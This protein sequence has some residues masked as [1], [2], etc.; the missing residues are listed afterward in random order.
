MTRQLITTAPEQV[1]F[2]DVDLPPPTP[3][4]IRVRSRWGAAKHGTE[5]ALY[6]GYAGPRGSY[7]GDLRLFDGN[8]EKLRY[9]S[10]LGNMCVGEVIGVGTEVT[11][12]AAG[13]MVFGHGPFRQEH[14][15]ESDRVRRLPEGLP[16]QAAVCLDPAD[17]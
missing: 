8:G 4:Q 3:T 5:M 6:K 2:G 11:A 15:W 9:P 10:P 17:L 1:A 13:D 16:W 12:F 7:D 14:V